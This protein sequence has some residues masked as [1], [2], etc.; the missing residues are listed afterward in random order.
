MVK[1][2]KLL[3]LFFISCIPVLS[4][5]VNWQKKSTAFPGHGRE[6]GVSFV[7]GGSAYVGTGYYYSNNN[8]YLN[9]FW[10]YDQ[11][12]G[13]WSRIADFPGAARYDA[14]AFSI[15]GKGYVGLG[16]SSGSNYLKDFYEYNPG[17]NTWSKIADFPGTG[18]YGAVAFSIGNAGYAGTGSDGTSAKG[19]FYK[20]ESGVWTAVASLP[21]GQERVSAT[22]FSTGGYGYVAA[23]GYV[24]AVGSPSNMY[25]Y[26]PN[27]N[28]WSVQVNYDNTVLNS[29]VVQSYVTDGTP[30]FC[31]YNKLVRYDL[32]SGSF[33]S[34]GDVFQLGEYFSGET[35]FVIS[36]VPYMTLGSDGGFFSPVLNVDLWSDVSAPVTGILGVETEELALFPN[37][38]SQYVNVTVET[39]GKLEI[40]TMGGVLVKTQE[41]NASANT[42]N[43]STLSNGIYII[44]IKSG[45]RTFTAKL[46][47]KRD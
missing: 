19:D 37:P 1:I 27:N 14:V 31:R 40:F 2:Y 22:A 41:V 4:S 13:S 25:K 17:T 16:S 12:S 47:V 24:G 35:F 23:G 21:S 44:R 33:T 46:V 20:Y 15:N 11:V 6:G 42:V 8:F 5:A 38:A 29:N 43:V 32:S 10:K 18:R 3:F 28:T 36:N 34:L 45:D 7:I 9:D 26:N 39:Y 30:Y